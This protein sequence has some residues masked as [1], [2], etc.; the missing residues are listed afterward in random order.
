MLSIH[1]TDKH[2]DCKMIRL[3][4]EDV[5]T[6][7]VLARINQCKARNE[8]TRINKVFDKAEISRSNFFKTSD[9]E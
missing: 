7:C 6:A 8:T 1:F 2:K 5:S 4:T 3:K 9:K